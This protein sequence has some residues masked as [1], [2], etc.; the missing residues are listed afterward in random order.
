MKVAVVGLGHWGPQIVRNMLAIEQCSRVVAGDLDESRVKQ[1]TRSHP[2]IEGSTRYEDVLVDPD[3]VGVIVATPV[4]THVELT[5][6]ALR[7]RKNVLVEK[8][9]AT[10]RSDAQRLVDLAAASGVLVMAGHTPLYSPAVQYAK[11]LIDRGEIGASLYVQSSRINLG[12]HQSDVS[13]IWDLGPHDLSV[14]LYWLGEHP[15][16]VSAS[17][18]STQGVGPPDVVFID[19]EFPSGCVANIHLSW[20]APTKMRRMT[21]VGSRRMFVFE[22][23]NVEEPL[24]LY[25]KGV[26]LP[27]PE[28]FA[29]FRATYRAGDVVSPRVEAW[30]PLRRELEDFLT[31][32]EGGDVPGAPEEAAIAVVAAA[33][34]AERSLEQQGFPTVP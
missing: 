11:R 5:E 16:R 2:A 9:M 8:P 20:L 34:A 1:T 21:V 29:G 25:D 31:R 18:R 12:M 15:T 19:L 32:I 10:S 22:D 17:G 13:V 30:E 26:T 14:L 24:K 27:D 4:S 23:S 7:A 6:L 28:D 33:E 3:V